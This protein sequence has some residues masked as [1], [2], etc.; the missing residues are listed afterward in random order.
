MSRAM[1]GVPGVRILNKKE[2]AEAFDRVAR[3]TVNMSGPE[4][5]EAWYRGDFPDPDGVPN[6]MNLVMMLPFVE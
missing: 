2:A 1:K 5:V 4:F 6:I 3:R